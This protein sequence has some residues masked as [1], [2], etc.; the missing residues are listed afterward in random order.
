MKWASQILCCGG[1]TAALPFGQRVRFLHTAAKVRFCG[2]ARADKKNSLTHICYLQC[3]A[4]WHGAYFNP[5]QSGSTSPTRPY[6]TNCSLGLPDSK[7][8]KQQ[9]CR[10]MSNMRPAS[11]SSH[12][13]SFYTP[14]IAVCTVRKCAL[15]II[16]SLMDGGCARAPP[17]LPPTVAATAER[18][19]GISMEAAAEQLRCMG[20]GTSFNCCNADFPLESWWNVQIRWN[21]WH[22]RV[23]IA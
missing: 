5:L 2:W 14:I 9:W 22:S 8:N 16:P 10:K 15:A 11:S 17:P 20:S 6:T 21:N 12:F 7:K 1:C 18:S 19:L 3:G 13:L 23:L 4:L